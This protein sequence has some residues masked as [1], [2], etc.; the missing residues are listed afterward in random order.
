MTA[1]HSKVS[2]NP[3]AGLGIAL[4]T[5][6]RDDRT[7]DLDAMSRLVRHTIDGGAD[8][9]LFMGTTGE[10]PTLTE[11][12]KVA[13]LSAIVRENEEKLPLVIGAG[14]NNTERLCNTIQG[15]LYRD[16][17]A[18]LVVAP[19]YNKPNQTGLY[20]H[21]MAVAEASPKPIILYNIPSR[22]GVDMSSELICRLHRESDKFVGIKE[23]TGKTIK[24]QEI[25]PH[26]D[27]NFVVL[28]GDDHLTRELCEMG[29]S[30]VVSVIGNA[31]PRIIKRLLHSTLSGDHEHACHMDEL[32]TEMYDLLFREGNPV[33]IKNLLRHLHI[34]E[35]D[36]V[37]LPLWRASQMLNDQILAAHQAIIHSS[38]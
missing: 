32:L 10:P 5:P 3:F 38:L 8:F 7:I 19:F 33:G 26:V 9:L 17:D 15:D 31:Y 29:A 18:L 24:S 28:S 1:H 30:G 13:L 25:I 14:D 37:R 35:S 36:N 20:H 23:A 12:E 22:T 16:A 21:F 4:V 6:F 27:E 2:S 34:V 11:P